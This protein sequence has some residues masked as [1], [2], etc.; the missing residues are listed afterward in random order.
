MPRLAAAVVLALLVALCAWALWFDRGAHVPNPTTGS[1]AA[2]QPA[3]VTPA[4]A[5]A[6]DA[7]APHDAA[8]ADRTDAAPDRNA[9][10]FTVRGFVL[11][12]SSAPDLTAVRVLAYR[13]DAQDTPGLMSAAL[14]GSQARPQ[15]PA[16]ALRGDPL[17]SA[18][19][20]ADGGFELQTREPHLRL[21]LDHD[22]YLLPAPEIVHVPTTTRA[23]DV[24]LAPML[25]GLVRGRLLGERTADVERVRLVLEPDPMS[26]LRD[27]RAMLAAMLATTKPPATPQSDGTFEFR[28]VTPG[29][30][31]VLTVDGGSAS[32]RSQ[33]PPLAPGE[34]RDVILAVAAGAVLTAVVVDEAGAPI[35]RATVAVRPAATSGGAGG[36]GNVVQTRRERTAADGRCTFAGLAP[37]SYAV[38]AQAAHLTAAE[39]HIEL[40]AGETAPD[41]RF[42][43]REGGVVTGTVLGPDG[44]PVAGA[45]A[46]HQPSMDLPLIGD[47][48]SQLGPDVL[49]A[50]ANDGVQTDA[51]GRFRLTGLADENA[52]LVVAAHPDHAVGI[53]RDVHMGDTDVT[54]T[55]Q[56][57]GSVV[58]R[59][60]HAGSD[61]PV[62]EF[63]VSLLR[64]SF[65]V[66]QVPVRREQVTAADGAFRLTGVPLGSYSLQIEADAKSPLQQGI[67]VTGDGDLDVGTLS[68]PAAARV[69]GIV[70]N[71]LGEPIRGALVQ[72]RRGAMA[73]NPMLAM[74][75]AAAARAYSNADGRFE[76]EPVEPGHLQ[77]IATAEGYASG[78][79]ERIEV[80]A[81]Q[82]VDGVLIELGH[83]G[84]IR[85]RVVC[86]AGQQPDDFTLMAQHQVTQNTKGGDI[87]P[88]G[89]FAIDNLDP[90]GYQVQVMPQRL[91][92]ELGGSD[93]KPGQGMQLGELMRKV[94]DNVVSQRCTVRSGET[95]EVTLDV[96]DLTVGARWLVRVEIGGKPL[97]SGVIEAVS[98]DDGTVRVAMLTEGEAAFGRMQPGR[99]RLQVRS[100]L[101]MT[102]VGEPQDVAYPAGADVHRSTLALPGGELRGRV[103]DA[104]TG[105]PLA[106][107]IVR[108]L[109]DG[110]AESDDPVGACLTDAGGEFSFT[111]LADGSYS[112]IAAEPPLSGA[113]NAASR[114]SGIAVV[115][116]TTAEPIELR[117]R[118]AAGASVLVTG[119]DG[120][121]LAGATVVCVD[122]QG[123]PLGALGVAATGADG[124]AWFGGMANGPA[125][126]VGRAPG[127]A[128][129]ASGVLQL[130]AE[131]AMEFTLTLSDGAPTRL[132]VVDGDGRRLRGAT[133]TARLGDGPWLP[134][135]LL[136]QGVAADG[137][138]DLGRLGP[139]DWQFRASHPAIGSVTI[140]RSIQGTAPVTI[141]VGGP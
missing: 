87:A 83:G 130:V 126:V 3:H 127:H 6:A 50:I 13:G 94:T 8:A 63:T 49:E 102:P 58:G 131:Q 25:G 4:A 31:M 132:S 32:A 59:V 28:G 123:R 65:M 89:S 5:T 67:E 46:A 105:A 43:L 54:V 74:F 81:G 107:A 7:P 47:L 76:L 61:E 51:D 12:D 109:H 84:A 71:D 16:F 97:Q 10:T 11:P 111:G 139:G 27:S 116:G 53:A 124:K 98:L 106:S 129:G 41:L 92:S 108:L 26:V 118:P 99:H 135:M 77:L 82:V 17:A 45:H 9:P 44:T 138:F 40:R 104:R 137:T 122:D 140:T 134:T 80:E 95:A 36:L 125:R 29:A 21:S 48:A 39:A 66:L 42:V 15:T 90:G 133:L 60:V 70:R 35:E 86:G 78:R 96:R 100:G 128:P 88:D 57:Q 14:A 114:R 38:D 136:V 20:A 121:P 101:S 75:Q 55:L 64:T 68:L 119:D 56:P 72:K 112:L 103:V 115:A 62:R 23:A 24:V 37:G 110:R 85:G 34:V 19:V 69:R 18:A 120:R 93:W 2:G 1:P 113:S 52:F 79:S 117:A 30:R 73:D 141:V 91:M 33:E 22:F